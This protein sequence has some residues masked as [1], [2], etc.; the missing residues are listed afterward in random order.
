MSK[1][2]AGNIH[3][4][5]SENATEVGEKTER[6]A[7]DMNGETIFIEY[8]EPELEVLTAEDQR[9]AYLK[10][11]MPVQF[12][13]E[14]FMNEP[15]EVTIAE[16][17]EPG[18]WPHVSVCVNGENVLFRRGEPKV[19][20]RKHVEALAH[21]LQEQYRQEINP[22]DPSQMQ[23]IGTRGQSYPFWVTKDTPQGQA[24]L[25]RMIGR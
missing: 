11:Q 1:A 9:K 18:T 17:H 8:N 6:V 14:K 10:S 15:V 12:A 4:P 7:V 3:I 22:T 21:A 5:E 13:I 23:M 20:K 24:W 2:N 19:V 25:K 16:T